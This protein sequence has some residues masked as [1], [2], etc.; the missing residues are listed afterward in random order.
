MIGVD[1][2]G[3][4]VF[5]VSDLAAW[6]S[7]ACGVLGLSVARR[8]SDGGLAL[9]MDSHSQRFLLEPGPADDLVAAGWQVADAA[10]LAEV[11]ARLRAAGVAVAAGSLEERQNRQ[12]QELIKFTDPAGIPTEVYFGPARAKEPFRSAVVASGYVAEELGLGHVVL[13]AR[14]QKES[15]DFYCRLLGF[16][17]SD[18]IVADV[19][20]YKADLVFL[21][22]NARHHS[23]ALAERLPK[24]I[25][26]FLIE[27]RTLDE[28]GLA[29]DRSLAAKVSIFQSIGRHPN[30]RMFSFYAKTPSGFQ[31]EFG[32]GGRLVDDTTWQPAAYDHISE[33]GHHPIARF[34]SGRK[35]AVSSAGAQK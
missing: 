25:H 18:R 20:G 21:H 29:F 17:L 12:V 11:A 2:L 5:Q 32:W 16:K 9:A 34:S 10:A 8:A 28:V 6:E 3:Y 22:V 14:S 33:W 13:S 7:F 15:Q 30:D 1:Q 19:Y 4:L 23:L 26:H 35:E 27:A 31:F 24:R